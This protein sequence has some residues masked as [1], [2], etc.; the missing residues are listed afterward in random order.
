MILFMQLQLSAAT[1]RELIL[2]VLGVQFCRDHSLH[3]KSSA[4]ASWHKRNLLFLNFCSAQ[5]CLNLILWCFRSLM[6]DKKASVS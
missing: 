2:A 1:T 3:S 5:C 6:C 4:Q